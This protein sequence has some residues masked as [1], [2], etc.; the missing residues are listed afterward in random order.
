MPV[1]VVGDERDKA[2]FFFNWL[3]EGLRRQARYRA[4]ELEVPKF[5]CEVQACLGGSN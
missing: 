2:R 5:L 1:K 3:F 4:G